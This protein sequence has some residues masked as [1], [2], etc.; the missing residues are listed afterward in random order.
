MTQ[1][2]K[3]PVEAA[4]YLAE[5]AS[6]GRRANLASATNVAGLLA[7]LRVIAREAREHAG[8]TLTDIETRSG[9]PAS[10]IS[11]FENTGRIPRQ[12]DKLI[13]AYEHEC[14]LKHNELWRRALDASD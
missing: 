10:T 11:R 7:T 13:A 2:L 14:G 3:L 4:P 5:T 8:I 6:T 1:M 9:I 12:L